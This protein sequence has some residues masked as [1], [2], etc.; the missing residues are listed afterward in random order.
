MNIRTQVKTQSHTATPFA[1]TRIADN[2]LDLIGQT[3]MVRLPRYLDRED[4]NLVAK[5]E[6][7]NPG[8]SAKDRPARHMIERALAG[9]STQAR[10]YGG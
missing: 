2:V 5:V 9:R 8:G 4:V 1:A 6:A 3:P 10:R 7:L